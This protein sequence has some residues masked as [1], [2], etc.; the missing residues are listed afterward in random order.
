MIEKYY[1]INCRASFIILSFLDISG[2]TTSETRMN[3][4]WAIIGL[5]FAVLGFSGILGI[6]SAVSSVI[7]GIKW[8]KNYLEERKNR[9]SGSAT[10]P[11][12]PQARARP[13]RVNRIKRTKAVLERQTTSQD[14][15][16]VNNTTAP[17]N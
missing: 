3:C 15:S 4:G 10:R 6:F 17:F 12:L 5:N 13:S 2:D 8:I 1:A 14:T 16:T 9:K 11:D 7:K